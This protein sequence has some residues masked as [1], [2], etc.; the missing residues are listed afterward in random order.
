M[1][2]LRSRAKWPKSCNRNH[3]RNN[4]N[5]SIRRADDLIRGSARF[6]DFGLI[7]VWRSKWHGWCAGNPI[8]FFDL[9]LQ[10]SKYMTS[11]SHTLC[12]SFTIFWVRFQT[13]YAPTEIASNSVNIFHQC[14][15]I[16]CVSKRFAFWFWSSKSP[17]HNNYA[18]Q[19]SQYNQYYI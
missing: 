18:S 12:V 7:H 15:M 2:L 6:R 8:V 1:A 13:K 5:G 4:P 14:N 19:I 17:W 9:I 11:E 16:L 10:S 3:S